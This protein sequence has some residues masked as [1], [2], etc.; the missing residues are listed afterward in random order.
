MSKIDK[1]VGK[2]LRKPADVSFDEVVT[3]L[4]AFGYS[5]RHSGTGSH[6]VFTRPGNLPI[7]VP[8]TKGRRV[9]GTYIRMIVDRLGLEE[10]Y[11][12]QSD[13]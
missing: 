7:I 13:S 1:L 3:L 5:E 2:F 12:K 6:R 8:T 9:K 11:E 10:Y 4:E